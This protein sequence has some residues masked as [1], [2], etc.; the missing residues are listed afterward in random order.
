MSKIKWTL[1]IVAG[2]SLSHCTSK[3]ENAAQQSNAADTSIHALMPRITTQAVQFD[4]DDPAI[5]VNPSN[6]EE[7]LVIGTDKDEQGGLYVFNLQGQIVDTVP[8]LKRPN[9][10]DLA[11]G[12]ELAG[13]ATDIVVATE[14]MTSKLRI[15]SVPDFRPLD[16]GGIEVFEGEQGPEF[17]DLM[18]IALYKDA[19]K[20]IYA[21]V[22]RKNGPT[23]GSYLWQYLLSDNGSGTVKAE[24]VRK[25]GH[26]SGKK[27]IEAIAVDQALGFVYY[28]DEGVGI[29]KYYADPGRGDEELALFGTTGFAEDNE[30]ISI[31]PTTDTT[32]YIIVSDQQRNAFKFFAREG[33][34]SG[35]HVHTEVGVVLASTVESDGNDIVAH[36]FGDKFPGGLFVAM[37]DN[38]T[39]QY[40]AW[41][42]MKA[43][44]KVTPAP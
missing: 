31:Y 19:D 20:R 1:W 42:D 13:K 16:K 14:R 23:G 25:F 7:G 39:F 33:D 6:P 24:L 22:G 29:R 41:D 21:I 35:A 26:F 37:S 8:G 36:S 28:C 9:N 5:W 2:I 10:V 15:F 43:A 17:R 30:G 32:G 27:E 12:L 4:T 11:Y 34:G 44:M 38:R 3:T 40:Y 18:G